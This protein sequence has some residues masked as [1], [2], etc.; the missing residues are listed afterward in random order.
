MLSTS[1]IWRCLNFLQSNLKYEVITKKT[2]GRHATFNSNDLI[3]IYSG[4]L[5][6]CNQ[7]YMNRFVNAK[8]IPYSSLK[9]FIFET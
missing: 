8:C 9:K 4:F 3:N 6:M 2:V 7:Y 5:I 1:L